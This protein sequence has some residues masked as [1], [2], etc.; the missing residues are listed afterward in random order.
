MDLIPI[1]TLIDTLHLG[2]Y[3]KAFKLTE[4]DF[5]YLDNCK[6]K[7]RESDFENNADLVEF[8]G[9]FFRI[10]SARKIYA[11]VLYNDDLTVKIARKISNGV[12]PEIFIEFR[13]RLLLGGLMDAYRAVIEWIETWAEISIEKV[14][15]ADIAQ[16]LQ[17]VIEID[18]EK[19]V[20][21]CRNNHVHC[22]VHRSGRKITGYTFGSG[23]LILRIYDKTEE[24]KV[25]GKAY[26]KDEWLKQ[27]WDGV[28]PIWRVEAQL[29]R[30]VIKEFKANKVDELKK[31]APDIWKYVT[32][33]W[34]TVR[35]ISQSD[36]TRS[37]WQ[38][39]SMWKVINESFKNL[40]MLTGIVR[41]RI[42]DVTLEKL[43]PQLSGSF[44]S[45]LALL[46]KARLPM[47]EFM[48]IIERNYRR[49]NKTVRE[50][51]EEKVK[52]YC[53]Y[54]EAYSGLEGVIYE[55]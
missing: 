49:K 11:Y 26:M 42:K 45:T 13:S 24:I 54:E 35:E 9:K 53:L 37:R 25:S 38:L 15:R 44:T 23:D 34:F 48:Q 36:K 21:R 41:E 1:L 10:T 2:L 31:N 40:G 50:V 28:T 39:S 51:V 4:D 32:G 27:G 43:I 22:D 3:L 55:G 8:K 52:K 33:E 20:M 17:G 47:S 46:K 29:R 7:A 5:K 6:K 18:S 30:K 14:S 19:M 12:Y 16:D